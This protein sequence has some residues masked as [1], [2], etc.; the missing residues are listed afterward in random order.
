MSKDSIRE[1]IKQAKE[2]AAIA[3][4][5]KGIPPE[6]K[7]VVESLLMLLEVMAAIFLEKTTRKNSSNS[8]LPPSRNDRPNGNRNKNGLQDRAK[9]GSDLETI[10]SESTIFFNKTLYL[11]P[12]L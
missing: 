3:L 7:V 12:S 10:I 1:K 2:D 9:F 4:S 11:S 5:K 8:G 6:L